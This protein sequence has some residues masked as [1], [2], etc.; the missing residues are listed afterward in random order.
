MGKYSEESISRIGNA[1]VYIAQHT[2]NLSKT[3]LLK[4]LYLMEERSAIRYHQP[5]LCLPYEVWQ[6]GPVAKDV[7]IDI[8]DGAVLLSK[9]VSVVNDED[10]Q[11]IVAKTDFDDSDFSNNEIS[12]MDEVLADYGDKTAKELV[13]ITH[14]KGSLWYNIA[15]KHGLIEA[16]SRHECNNSNF[17]IDFTEGMTPCSAEYYREALNTHLASNSY[18]TMSLL[19]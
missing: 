3:K 17:V 12:L 19:T 14:R 5:F 13:D 16:F 4:L 7:Y 10:A 2:S 1:A 9:Y 15:E 6:A 11:Y 8:S 18:S